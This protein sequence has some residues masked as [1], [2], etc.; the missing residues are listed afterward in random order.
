LSFMSVALRC[1]EDHEGRSFT[2]SWNLYAFFRLAGI[3]G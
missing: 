3:Q 2:F 1:P